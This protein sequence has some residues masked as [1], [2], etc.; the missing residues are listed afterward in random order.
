MCKDI[1]NI[2]AQQLHTYVLILQR[3]KIVNKRY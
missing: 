1:K 3:E 2:R